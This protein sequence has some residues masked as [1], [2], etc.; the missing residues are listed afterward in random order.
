MGLAR[1]F[2]ITTNKKSTEN[3]HAQVSAKFTEAEAELLTLALTIA[4]ETTKDLAKVMAEEAAS[5][6]GSDDD[7]LLFQA[8]Q[9]FREES[10][11]RAEKFTQLYVKLVLLLVEGKGDVAGLQSEATKHVFAKNV[12]KGDRV[13]TST[14]VR[15]VLRVVPLDARRVAIVVADP[16]TAS[17][18]SELQFKPDAQVLVKRGGV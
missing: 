4:T 16:A 5:R 12:E 18:E 7:D 3:V 8:A 14:G 11:K 13:E 10:E 2:T 9:R 1:P 6:A 17:G 15:T